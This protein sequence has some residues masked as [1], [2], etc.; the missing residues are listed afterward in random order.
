MMRQWVCFQFIPTKS[1]GYPPIHIILFDPH[2]AGPP[3]CFNSLLAN[4]ENK[5][6]ELTQL[7]ILFLGNF[8]T[9]QTSYFCDPSMFHNAYWTLAGDY[10]YE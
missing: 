2:E 5:T 9:S 8:R 4:S 7:Y 10:M 6:R 1:I 3:C